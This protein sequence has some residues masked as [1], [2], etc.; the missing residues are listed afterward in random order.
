MRATISRACSLAV[1]LFF[2]AICAAQ[3]DF[4]I[5]ALPDTQNESQ[6]FPN[7]L[8][9][10][11]KWI[12]DNQ[13]RLNIRM[14][15]G[16]G[17]IVN[18]FS[19]PEQQESSD[20]A[21]RV[22]DNA[23]IPYMLAIGNHDYDDAAPKNGRPVKGFNRFFGP[24]RYAGK[25]YYRGNFP[26]GS[27]ENFF[28]VLNI[29]GKD[30]LF[31]ILEFMPR[32]ES[33]SWA[34]SILQANPDKEAIVVTHSFTYIDNTRVDFCDT[35]DMP[36]GNATGD[37]LW[38]TL[39]KFPNVIMV[40]SG[41]LTNGQAGHRSDIADGGNLVNEMMANYQTFPNG[42]DGW[43]RILTFHPAS[44]TISVQTFSPFLK[45]FKTDT[46][47]QFTVPYHNP[48]LQTGAGTLSGMV[49]NTSDCTPVAGATISTAGKS[50]TTDSKGRY[51]LQLAPGP[52]QVSVSAPG[53]TGDT[54][55]E[56]VADGFDTDL[57]FFLNAGPSTPCPPNSASPSITICSPAEDA[58]VTS[59]VTVVAETTDKNPVKT[60][61]AFLD[62]E[63][64]ST[65]S[66]GTLTAQISAA[67]GR[68][69]LTIQAKDNQGAI[70]VNSIDFT[71]IAPPV[72]PAPS[73]LSMNVSPAQATISLGRSAIFTLAVGSDG[74]L[75]QPVAFACSG[76][77][78]GVHCA[79]DQA[80]IKPAKL[81]ANI[82]LTISTLP[83]TS[84]QIVGKRLIWAAILLPCLV[85][86]PFTKGRQ[87]RRRCVGLLGAV[88]VVAVVIAG[89]Q[90]LTTPSNHGSFA[91]TV[92]GTSADV[93]SSTAINLTLN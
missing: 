33:V 25:A 4:T 34:K 12:A 40:L 41:H 1:V 70:F 13:D 85:V 5:I 2:S 39:R 16:E 15:L 8:S 38:Q 59:P 54:K 30:F 79:F 78:S 21:F 74:S 29:G 14:V 24:S 43:L 57:N 64:V 77:P 67:S 49:R 55:N 36:A 45:R 75:T 44:N 11:T 31:L 69:S 81:P 80:R 52:Y 68:H 73:K 51:S 26:T 32:P 83:V 6:F 82:K 88:M 90:G 60:M 62:G 28:G 10:Q 46:R 22:L 84:A 63:T 86:L 35:N 65:G 93:Q 48:H 92:T 89:C 56:T 9:S 71:V 53:A 17:D 72:T 47:N 3:T 37:D 91:V 23:G 42:G 19:D 58:E 66:G 27:N 20:S 7:V 50:V 87:R 18:D 61:Q 76:L